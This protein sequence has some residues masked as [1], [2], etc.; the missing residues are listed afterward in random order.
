[1]LGGGAGGDEKQ[2]MNFAWPYCMNVEHSD[3]YTCIKRRLLI[4]YKASAQRP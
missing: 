1:M 2:V 4:F 3:V